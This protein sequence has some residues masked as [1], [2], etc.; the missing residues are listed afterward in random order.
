MEAQQT[1][2]LATVRNMRIAQERG[3]Q[4]F[5]YSP[6]T[7]EQS[8]ATPGDYF[9]LGED[10]PLTD[11]DGNPMHLVVKATRYIDALG[12]NWTCDCEEAEGSFGSDRC[13]ACGG[14]IDS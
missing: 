14:V 8:S 4:A 12:D 11:S 7:L 6:T 1:H 2:T 13:R 9:M 3:K 10:E 5:A